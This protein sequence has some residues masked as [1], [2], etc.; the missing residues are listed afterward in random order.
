MAGQ[1]CKKLKNIFMRVHKIVKNSTFGRRAPAG[2]TKR[3]GRF[4]NSKGSGRGHFYMYIRLCA[5]QGRGRYASCAR[6]SCG[7]ALQ[8]S[9]AATVVK[10][11]SGIM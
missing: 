10:M 6:N 2:K 9:T 5:K 11:V 1:F 7:A 4:R 8:I 3:P